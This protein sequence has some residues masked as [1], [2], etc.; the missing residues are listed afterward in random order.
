VEE[1]T[2]HNGDEIELRLATMTM[3][4][5]AADAIAMISTIEPTTP[6]R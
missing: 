4:A 1:E 2:T 5:D 6:S 3:D